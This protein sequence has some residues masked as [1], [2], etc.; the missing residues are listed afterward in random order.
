MYQ[1]ASRVVVPDSNF[2]G[3][4]PHFFVVRGNSVDAH[5]R[6]F[7]D[8]VLQPLLRGLQYKL[9]EIE[10]KLPSVNTEQVGFGVIQIFNHGGQVVQQIASG[11]SNIQ[12]ATIQVQNPELQTL[13]SELRVLADKSNLEP[14]QVSAAK[15]LIDAVESELAT[16]KPK[17]S[18]VGSLLN[19]LP[20]AAAA[21]NLIA[22]IMKIVGG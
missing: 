1:W 18:V 20:F 16:A 5:I 15:E 6:A 9:E 19:A 4:L 2:I 13:L 7:R 3:M 14:K 12:T 11:S 10:E 22:G 17:T 8:A 21:A